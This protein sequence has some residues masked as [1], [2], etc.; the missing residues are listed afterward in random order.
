[1]VVA[2]ASRVAYISTATSFCLSAHILTREIKEAKR[3][4]DNGKEEKIR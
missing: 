4:L 3:N 2:G 1:M